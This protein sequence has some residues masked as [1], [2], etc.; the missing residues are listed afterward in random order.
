MTIL[1]S[2]PVLADEPIELTAQQMDQITAGAGQGNAGSI[3]WFAGTA[4]EVIAGGIC[5]DGRVEGALFHIFG[6]GGNSLTGGGKSDT[7]FVP[8]NQGHSL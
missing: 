1:L 7:V 3:A 8:N 2:A 5:C 4:S 6:G